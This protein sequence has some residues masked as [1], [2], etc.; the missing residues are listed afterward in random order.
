MMDRYSEGFKR[1]FSNT[2]WLMAGHVVRMVAGLLVW[3]WLA[4][5][6]GPAEFG[7]L[8]YAMAFVGLFAALA[9]VG[10]DGVLVRELVKAP[11]ARERLLGSAMALKLIG[12]LLMWLVLLIV[13]GLAGQD[14]ST[15]MLVG[16]IAASYLFQALNVIDTV[17]Q[18]QVLSRYV[19]KA[20]IVQVLLSSLIKIG[21]IL[22]EAPLFWFAI[23]S[24]VDA[25]LLALMLL[26]IYRARQGAIGL[27]RIDVP[28]MRRLLRDSWPLILSGMAVSAYMRIDQVMIN[29]QIDA[30]AVGYYAVAIRLCEAWYFIPVAIT[31][32]L[33]PAIMQAR[34]AGESL[35]FA[36][37]QRLH[38]LMVLIS[39]LIALPL[40]LLADEMIAML[41]GEAY[42]SAAPVL[43]IYAWVVL[44]VSFGMASDKYLLAENLPWLSFWRT[45]TGLLV[46]VVLNYLL[47]GAYGLVG[48]AIAT[49]IS[50][51]VA[52]YIFD[53]L[54]HRC[55]RIWMIKNR[56]LLGFWRLR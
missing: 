36:R 45:F 4:R 9:S 44:F 35:Y 54:D 51:S 43:A 19:A 2:S 15:I 17:F 11:E 20:Q 47:I 26:Y 8:N 49:L 42:A 30:E 7:L 40:C 12:T 27:W 33:F 52:A 5:Y 16:V 14:D 6:L 13:V 29:Q 56:A 21:L 37:L 46:N 41:Y 39:L 28:L 53:L 10:V 18:A 24:V 1:Y 48:A 22:G 50:Y 31:A 3:V 23:M 55:R 34:E 25:A 38:N 32:S